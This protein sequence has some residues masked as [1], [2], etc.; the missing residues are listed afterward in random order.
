MRLIEYSAL[1][2]KISK[3]SECEDGIAVGANGVCLI[4][5]ATSVSKTSKQKARGRKAMEI[6]TY[7]F[8]VLPEYDEHLMLS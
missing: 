1:G 5:G 7:A 4:D 2:K 6:L 3:T 8:S